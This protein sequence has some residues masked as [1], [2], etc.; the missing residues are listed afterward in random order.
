MY[1]LS[2]RDMGMDCDFSAMAETKEAL[3]DKMMDHAKVDHKDMLDKMSD[4]E[5]KDLMTKMEEKMM[6]I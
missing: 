2:C 4:T 5:K 1:K 6:T 3:M